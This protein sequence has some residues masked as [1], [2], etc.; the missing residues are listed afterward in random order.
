M[1][2]QSIINST[3]IPGGIYRHYKGMLYKAHGMVKHSESLE[4]M[5]LYETLYENKHGK[6]WVRPAKMWSEPVTVDGKTVLR[7]TL[8]E[9]KKA[10]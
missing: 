7:F 5:V 10:P 6:L 2:N 8:V 3:I 9:N 1:E 4:D